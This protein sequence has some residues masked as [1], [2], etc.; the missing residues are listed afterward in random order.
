MRGH[1]YW[2]WCPIISYRTTRL[3]AGYCPTRQLIQM[4]YS[5]HGLRKQLAAF[6]SFQSFHCRLQVHKHP[7]FGT[8]YTKTWLST[9]LQVL[10]WYISILQTRL[11]TLASAKAASG[12]AM[13]PATSP[14]MRR[15]DGTQ[16][17]YPSKNRVQSPFSKPRSINQIPTNPFWFLKSLKT[18]VP[19]IKFNESRSVTV[20]HGFPTIFRQMYTNFKGKLVPPGAVCHALSRSVTR[21][22]TWAVWDNMPPT[23]RWSTQLTGIF[24]NLAWNRTPVEFNPHKLQ[25]F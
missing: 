11:S 5:D 10:N 9:A 12:E 17:C 22:F 15:G 19:T 21:C 4:R 7:F 25:Q 1:Q 20:C 2:R 8:V 18:L 3:F 13:L 6:S 16:V 23:F 14:R 24:L